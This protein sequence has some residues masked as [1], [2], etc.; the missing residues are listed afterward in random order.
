LWLFALSLC[1]LLQHLL[2]KASAIYLLEGQLPRE[3]RRR[4]EPEQAK[5]RVKKG[6]F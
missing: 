1:C 4:I 5:E 3:Q 2:K 6:K